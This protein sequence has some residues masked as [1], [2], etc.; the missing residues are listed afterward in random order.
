MINLELYRIFY[1]VAEAGNIT[2]A[3]ESLNISQPAVSKQIKNLEES[4]GGP[5]FIRTSKGVKLNEVGEKMFIKVKQALSLINDAEKSFEDFENLTIG[6]IKVGIST[7]LVKK[8]LVKYIKKFHELYPNILIEISTDPTSEMIKSLKIGLIDFIIAKLPEYSDNELEF[9]ILGKMD[10]IFIAGEKYNKLLNEN[11]SIKDLVN[12]PILLQ[13]SPSTSR[14]TIDNYCKNNNISLNTVMNIASSN[15]L[16]DFV[17]AG[18]GIGFVTK[19]Y[20]EEELKNKE[21]FEINLTP[22]IEPT[23]FGIIKLKNNVLSFSA[24]KFIQTILKDN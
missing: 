9:T 7:T 16:I 4:L 22:K 11:L 1:A 12:Y 2:K 6:T 3:S 13:K 21:L 8:Y 14:R 18:Y 5:L 19:N 15:L 24:L 23:K 20:V 17:K 10:N